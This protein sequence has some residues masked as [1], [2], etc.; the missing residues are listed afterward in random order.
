MSTKQR[1]R[2]FRME[3][4]RKHRDKARKPAEPKSAK[5]G[6]YARNKRNA[7]RADLR[8]NEWNWL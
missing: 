7:L 2:R 5:R 8:T 3:Q 4:E 6:T 1:D